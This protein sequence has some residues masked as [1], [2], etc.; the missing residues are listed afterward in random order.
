MI[1]LSIISGKISMLELSI[2]QKIA[3]WIVPILSAITLHEA[4]HAYIANYFGDTTAKMLGRLSL[5]PMK[6]IDPIGTVLVPILVALLTQFSFVFGWA[7]PVPINWSQLHNP[8]RD[9][10]L[11]ALAGPLSNLGMA[12]LWAFCLKIGLMMDPKTSKVALFLLLTGNAGVIINLI[13]CVLNLIPLPPLDGSR[14]VSSVLPPKYSTTYER[15]EPFGLLILVLLLVTGILGFIMQ[16]ILQALLSL[17][18]AIFDL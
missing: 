3:I 10:A 12:L 9:M 8:R 7:K 16:P 17:L 1:V 5:N 14:V 18:Q 6:H 4:S 2:V 13:L 15:L 11:V